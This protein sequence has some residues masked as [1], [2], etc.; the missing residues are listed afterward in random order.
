MVIILWIWVALQ[1]MNSN[2]FACGNLSHPFSSLL[3]L[4]NFVD[5]SA[6]PIARIPRPG[7]RK[8]GRID[9][10]LISFAAGGRLNQ[11]GTVH[12]HMDILLGNLD[13][14][15]PRICRQVQIRPLPCAVGVDLKGSCHPIPLTWH[16]S[17][18]AKG[19]FTYKVNRREPRSLVQKPRLMTTI[20][21]RP[22]SHNGWLLSLMFLMNRIRHL[23]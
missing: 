23:K 22:L 13:R 17:T 4:T 15:Y 14:V 21:R 12:W 19:S 3:C 8:L 1:Y 11:I 20:P 5:I 16:G 6:A 9:R 18:L 2:R 7:P 10:I